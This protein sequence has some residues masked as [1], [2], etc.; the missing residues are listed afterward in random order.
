MSTFKHEVDSATNRW[1]QRNVLKY[2]FSGGKQEGY[3]FTL[4]KHH[5]LHHFL[6]DTGSVMPGMPEATTKTKS[7]LIDG[8][9]LRDHPP[10]DK[11]QGC[12][13]SF[14][15]QFDTRDRVVAVVPFPDL[16]R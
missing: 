12:G 7:L 11:G 3:I 13:N 1:F 4:L 14:R 2:M 9:V 8:R 10:R 6:E 16:L 5:D 15:A